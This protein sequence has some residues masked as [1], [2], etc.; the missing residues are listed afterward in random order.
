MAI[1]IIVTRVE[2]IH[3]IKDNLV[4]NNLFITPTLPLLP[5][6]KQAGLYNLHQS[7]SEVIDP[8]ST[9]PEWIKDWLLMPEWMRKVNG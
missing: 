2:V 9:L 5:Q 8:T 4:G 3:K 1:K 7:F 6:F